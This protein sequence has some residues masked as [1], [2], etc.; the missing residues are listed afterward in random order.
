MVEMMGESV[1]Q[2]SLS[3]AVL[4]YDIAQDDFEYSNY[5]FWLRWASLTTSVLS[6]FLTTSEYWAYKAHYDAC[7]EEPPFTVNLRIG[8][9]NIMNTLAR[10]VV[11]FTVQRGMILLFSKM[12]NFHPVI[13]GIVICMLYSVIEYCCLPLVWCKC[14]T[15]SDIVNFEKSLL[16]VPMFGRM[17]KSIEERRSARIR[18]KGFGLMAVGIALVA[19]I[20]FSVTSKDEVNMIVFMIL[21]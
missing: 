8:V 4:L 2:F 7:S 11:V 19:F 16:L 9:I 13:S 15:L 17:D 5:G 10:L 12:L 1:L 3:Y 14:C 20:I 18:N 21:Y 6:I